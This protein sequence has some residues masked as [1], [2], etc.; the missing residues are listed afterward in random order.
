MEIT[1]HSGDDHNSKEANETIRVTS[2]VGDL[3]KNNECSPLTTDNE[4]ETTKR[5]TVQQRW[6]YSYSSTKVGL[7]LGISLLGAIILF[8]SGDGKW[9]KQLNINNYQGDNTGHNSTDS[10]GN[11]FLLDVDTS[12]TADEVSSK[13]YARDDDEND[14]SH[15]IV[16]DDDYLYDTNA[17][18]ISEENVKVSM[19]DGVMYKVLGKRMFHDKT[20]F[21]QGLTYSNSSNILF[22]S[23]G[24]YGRS[25]ICKLNPKF[26]T[27]IKCNVMEKKYFAEGM[28]VYGEPGNEK[29]IQ[30]TW[31]QRNGFIYDARSLERIDTFTFSTTNNEGWGIC[32]DKDNHEFIVSDGSAY[33]HFWDADS[34]EE[35]RR[36]LVTRQ[37]G[38]NAEDINELEFVKGRVLANVWYSDVLLVI[39]PITGECEK[40]YD[41]SS[42]WSQMDRNAKGADVL[43]GISVSKEEGVLY[44]T[45]K[46]WDRMFLVKLDHF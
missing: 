32:Y 21:T 6:P 15:V 27:I 18:V 5:T 8:S 43:N 26:G 7:I 42:L 44:I 29:L 40:E 30:L 4:T 1:S 23:N 16:D 31:K 22:E 38:M 24:L 37:S 33:L 45:G 9:M 14:Q 39:N 2:S 12:N 36:L 3:N 34:L 13:T 10:V 41:M 11:D 17:K 20:H 28:Q 25:S 19:Y 46:K 35:K